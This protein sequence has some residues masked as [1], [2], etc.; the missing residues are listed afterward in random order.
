MA[1]D[2][3]A[4]H[5]R[6]LTRVFA[7]RSVV[8]DVD[9]NVPYGSIVALVGGNGSG[10]T[11]TIRMLLGLL[12]PTRGR[13]A[14]LGCDSDKLT[15]EIRAR[16]GYVAEGHFIY[17]WMRVA[18]CG[19]FQALT[20]LNWNQATFDS[21]VD[22]FQISRRAKVKTLSRGQRAGL[23][24]ALAL[25]PEPELLVLD[26]PAL[27]LDPLARRSLVETILGV[28]RSAGRTVLISSHLLDD[29]ERMADRIAL[30]DNGRLLAHC[31]TEEFLDRIACWVLDFDREPPNVQ[32]LDGLISSQV[33]GR[34]IRVVVANPSD[35]VE[36]ELACLGAASVRRIPIGL[37][38]ALLSYLGRRAPS[39]WLLRAAGG[40][41]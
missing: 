15:P 40:D 5:T 19:R 12:A 6:S 25:A 3:Y 9:I 13:S 36:A 7:G 22:Y 41:A 34:R 1:D 37:E 31:S 14:V 32:T 29:V 33:T 28:A 16:I 8:C 27:G 24:L 23:C 30:V 20:Y 10:K 26:E 2:A 18:E 17:R 11:T 4:I 35:S 39:R 38:D 21:I